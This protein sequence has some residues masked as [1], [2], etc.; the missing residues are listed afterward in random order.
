MEFRLA[1]AILATLILVRLETPAA[2]Q[3]QAQVS[4]PQQGPTE[5]RVQ[6]GKSLLITSQEPL[7]RVSVTDPTVA[8]A[9]IISPTQILIHGIKAGSGTLIL[10]DAQERARSFNLTVEL[11]INALRGA[12]GQMFPG[13]SLQIMQ[14]GGAVVL[15]GNV[16]NKAVADRAAAL[17]GTLSPSVVNLITTTEGRQIV[18]LQVRFAEVDRTAVQQVGM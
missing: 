7:Q 16:S 1:L 12:I 3:P 14:S 13:E 11:D 6:L 18:L 17:A 5:I 15:T 9:I 8:S 4:L 10:W 2:T